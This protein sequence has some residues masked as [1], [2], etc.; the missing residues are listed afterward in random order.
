[1][2]RIVTFERT[3]L[4]ILAHSEKFGTTQMYEAIEQPDGRYIVTRY[5][6]ESRDHAFMR[7]DRV[8]AE[9]S[10]DEIVETLS[11]FAGSQL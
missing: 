8:D 11:D 4:K 9:R 1:M 6:D 5:E 10:L 7:N 3:G 2:K